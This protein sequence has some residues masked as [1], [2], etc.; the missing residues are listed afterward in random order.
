MTGNGRGRGPVPPQELSRS[1]RQFW[2][3]VLILV[4]LMVTA[5]VFY[6]AVESQLSGIQWSLTDSAYFAVLV[7]TTIG[8]TEVHR[9]S[10]PGKV[11]T[12]LFAVTSLVMVA[13]AARNSVG[14]LV[15]R[16]LL[17]EEMQRRRRE[18]A[19]RELHNHYIVCGY[20]RMGKETVTQ[21]RRRGVPVAA[22]EQDPAALELLRNSG[23]PFVEGNATH[24][25]V[26]KTAGVEGAK[27]LV[28]AVGKDED[29]LFIVFSARLLNPHLYIVARA[30][31]D[32]TTDKLTRA[33]A[34]RVLS[35]YVV[36]GRRLAAAA[37]E[38][39][40]MDVLEMVLH[41]EVD[42][43]IASVIIP[44]DSPVLGRSLAESGVVREDGA[45]VLAL[46]GRKNRIH[47]NPPRDAWLNSGDQLIVIGSRDQIAA[48][49]QAVSR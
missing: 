36:G 15:G 44:P 14:V 9:L 40:V 37:A 46:I 47:T 20:G 24:D 12:I 31:E 4:A 23:I 48:L 10:D 39:G 41:E 3:A 22:I 19:L 38:P 35:P 33:G 2:M 42:V 7:M 27:C 17:S 18:K 6:A 16:E 1:V 29:N 25:E 13:W 30:G 43:E 11:F 32:A 34:N 28:A 26:L 8:L 21:L 5:V 45:M 49:K